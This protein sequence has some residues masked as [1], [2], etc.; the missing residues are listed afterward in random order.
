MGT[1]WSAGRAARPTVDTGRC[2]R[3]EEPAVEARV[4]RLHGQIATVRIVEHA[5]SLHQIA[6]AF[7]RNYDTAVGTTSRSPPNSESPMSW[8]D[9]LRLRQMSEIDQRWHDDEASDGGVE[10]SRPDAAKPSRPWIRRADRDRR[11]RVRLHLDESEGVVLLDDRRIPGTHDS[12]ACIAVS[13]GGVFIIDTKN[14]KG[15]VHTKRPGPMSDLGPYE[16]YVGRRNCTRSLERVIDG[17]T[18]VGRRS[19]RRRGVR[20]AHPS[21]ALPHPCRMGLRLGHRGREVWV[22]WPKLVGTR[23]RSQVVMDSSTIEE[24]SRLIADSLPASGPH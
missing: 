14:Y 17:R 18:V 19:A 3:R 11:A 8:P 2:D 5:I 22:G 12:I 4:T 20:G 6:V 13:P 1:L 7:W 15:L 9:F 21:H 16:L 24:V 23:I 10:E